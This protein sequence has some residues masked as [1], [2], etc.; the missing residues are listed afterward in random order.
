MSA[1]QVVLA[2]AVA[3]AATL[4]AGEILA[5]ADRSA[6]PKPGPVRPLVVPGIERLSLSNGLAVHLVPM[7]EVPVVEVALVVRAGAT[8][9]PAGREGLASMTADMLDEGAG[10]KDALAC[11][12]PWTSSAPGS[13]R[14]P[15]GTP[16][17]FA[18]A[19][20]SRGC[21]RRCR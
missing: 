12:T 20:R 5:Q 4:A 7:H 3:A 8:A 15:A 13:R 21:A 19:C 18:C 10:G 1:R 9:D 6:P 2:A 17:P 16:R 11:P 14:A